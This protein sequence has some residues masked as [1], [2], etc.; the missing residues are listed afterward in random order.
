VSSHAA[1]AAAW[2][3]AF[4]ATDGA[5]AGE[6]GCTATLVL[7]EAGPGGRVALQCANV[8]DSAALLVDM[9]R[10]GRGQARG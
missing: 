1:A 6:D 8:G 2:E 9:A 4:L 10:W 7:L 5:L 3:A